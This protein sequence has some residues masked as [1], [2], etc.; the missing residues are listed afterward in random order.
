MNVNK[1]EVGKVYRLKDTPNYT[2]V[3]PVEIIRP[4]TWQMDKMAKE[5]SKKP[6]RFIVVKCEHVVN[7]D[8]TAGFIRY[9]R[10]V[11]I[12]ECVKE[13]ATK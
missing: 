6:F 12:I 3:R 4:N 10:P 9:F 2:Y 8:D 7:K 1:I 11:D 5:M 13:A